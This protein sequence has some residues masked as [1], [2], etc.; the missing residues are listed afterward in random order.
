MYDVIVVGAGPAGCMT[1][2]KTAESGYNVLLIE[3]MKVPREK[4]C[5]GILIKKA[6]KMVE[7][8]FGRIP[9]DV[10]CRPHVNKGIIVTNE[11]GQ[12]FKFESKGLNI[13]RSSFDHWMALKAED[14]GA[15]FRPLT[16][17]FSCENRQG[18]VSVKMEGH[19]IYNEKAK[20]V[21]VC[22][23][24]SSTIKRKLLDKQ[25]NYIFTYQSFCNGFVD[26]DPN[27]FHAFM[28]HELSQYD[29]WFNVKDDFLIFGV[30][31]NDRGL[32]KKYHKHFLSFL[33]TRFNAQ[34]NILNGELGVM[35]KILPERSIDL[36]IG[37][38]LFAGEAANLLNP[39]GEGISIALSS[40]YAAA[41]AIKSNSINESNFN[42]ELLINTY[43]K[44]FDNEKNYMMRQWKY[45]TKIS[46]KFLQM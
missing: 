7:S 1:A 37:R 15:E 35:P 12:M 20:I 2:K 36:G 22:D 3:K 8:E 38:V 5:S 44:N 14:A 27:F 26:L 13:W 40:G 31:V 25:N 43:E 33:K 24:A 16:S 29:A 18:H 39:I 17:A 6:V 34:I 21:V 11:N 10:L 32:I 9:K 28:N 45:L 42:T 41:E 46:P 4:S 19:Y 30:A 23:G